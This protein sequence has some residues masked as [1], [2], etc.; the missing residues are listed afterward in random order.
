M[1]AAADVMV[2]RNVGTTYALAYG[3]GFL[4]FGPLSD[5]Y[6]RKPILVPGMASVGHR[7]GGFG[8]GAITTGVGAA[9]NR[10]GTGGSELLRR[11]AGLHWR[12]ASTALAINGD[13]CNV[14]GLLVGRHSGSGLCA[15]GGGSPWAPLGIRP[16]GTGVRD[17]GNRH[18][19]DLDRATR[20]GN[21]RVWARSIARWQAW[22]S[23][24]SWPS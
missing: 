19:R 18:G 13:W 20:N 6:G 7:H 3:L 12:S 9:A 17:R 2:T 15:S 8:C 4:I 10:S 11:G 22:Q 21:G 23:G 16:G 14:D 24:A 5:P 1:R